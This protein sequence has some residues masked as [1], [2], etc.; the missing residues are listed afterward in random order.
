ML[1]RDWVNGGLEIVG[2]LFMAE[3]VRLL[4]RD[5]KVEGF[6]PWS[7]AFTT[8]CCTWNVG[9]YGSLSLPLSLIG[10]V[11]VVLLQLVWLYLAWSYR[12]R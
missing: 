9:F 3:N 11:L 5:K 8:I 12:C 4:Y 7:V 6:S 1:I 10:A 2:A